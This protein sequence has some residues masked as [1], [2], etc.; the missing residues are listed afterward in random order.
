MGSKKCPSQKQKLEARSKIGRTSD[1]P[2][3][4]LVPVC[5]LIL[6]KLYKKCYIR[7]HINHR[8]NH[9]FLKACTRRGSAKLKIKHNCT[10]INRNEFSFIPANHR[11]GESI[12]SLLIPPLPIQYPFPSLPHRPLRWLLHRPLAS[13]ARGCHSSDPRPPRCTR[14][15]SFP[16]WFLLLGPTS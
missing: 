4:K 6:L 2:K 12:H 11:S 8:P 16:P 7:R 10:D 3:C 15:A 14:L 9:K 13:E 5:P 1:A